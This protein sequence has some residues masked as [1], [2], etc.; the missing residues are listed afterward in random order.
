M[1]YDEV[2]AISRAGNRP[3]VGAGRGHLFPALAMGS[4]LRQAGRLEGG[5]EAEA[6]GAAEPG[7]Q[8]L[9]RFAIVFN[10]GDRDQH[11][12]LIIHFRRSWLSSLLMTPLCALL[13][14]GNAQADSRSFPRGS[15]DFAAA[16]DFLETP[17]GVGQS[18]AGGQAN[19]SRRRRQNWRRRRHGCPGRCAPAR[20]RLHPVGCHG[21]RRKQKNTP[22]Q[23]FFP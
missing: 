19:G 13:S 15:A 16:A 5:R 21:P 2:A 9:P 10:N 7:R 23:K 1:G 20:A 18:V 4:L 17:F 14:D 11:G 22:A 12:S 3:E 6:F 8:Y